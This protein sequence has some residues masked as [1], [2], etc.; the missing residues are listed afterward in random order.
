MLKEVVLSIK[1]S[2][3]SNYIVPIVDDGDILNIMY[4]KFFN[5]YGETSLINS[6]IIF[7]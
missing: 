2:K 3:S 1:K 6:I 5:L 7:I 4:L